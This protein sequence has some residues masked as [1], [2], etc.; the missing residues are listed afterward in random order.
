MKEARSPV[1]LHILNMIDLNKKIDTFLEK[2]N[3]PFVLPK[4]FKYIE[5]DNGLFVTN[6]QSEIRIVK[7]VRISITNAIHIKQIIDFRFCDYWIDV[8][9]SNVKFLWMDHSSD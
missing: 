1:E 6:E 9:P 4:K 5:H 3:Q 2:A 8:D 7:G